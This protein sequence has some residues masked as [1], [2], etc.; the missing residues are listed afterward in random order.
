MVAD[1]GD[2]AVDHDMEKFGLTL[3][4]RRLPQAHPV[5]FESLSTDT[6]DRAA[7]RST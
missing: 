6:E 7:T 3:Q 5:R 2:F 4:P 1:H